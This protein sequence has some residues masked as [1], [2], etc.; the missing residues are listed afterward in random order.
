[1][2]HPDLR[3]IFALL[4]G[5]L[6]GD[7]RRELERHLDG[8]ADCAAYRARVDRVGKLARQAVQA[9]PIPEID[10]DRMESRLMARIAAP[11]A[12]PHPFAWLRLLAPA[13]IAA[14]LVLAIGLQT[15]SSQ[16]RPHD[17][18]IALGPVAAASPLSLEGP[19]A[20][21]TVTLLSGKAKLAA[22][23]GEP[24]RSVTL[25][26]TV[27]EGSL[28]ETAD[29]AR[30]VVQ[31]AL[32]TGF[33]V[34]GGS[35]VEVSAL[36]RGGSV[37]VL[38]SGRVE[39][40]VAKLAPGGAYRVVAGDFLVEVR[41]TRFAVE[42]RQEQTR[43]EVSEGVVS[44]RRREGRSPVAQ[45]VAPAQAT[46]HDGEPPDRA[47]IAHG[48][49]DPA[50]LALY[51]LPS[52]GG[53]S[54]LRIPPLESVRR[55]EV[56]GMDVGSGDALLRHAR[57][58]AEVVVYPLEGDPIRMTVPVDRT[59][60]TFKMPEAAPAAPPT[61]PSGRIDRAAI[62]A[63]MAGYRQQVQRCYDRRLKRVPTLRDRIE[64]SI[65]IGSDGAVTNAQLRGSGHDA[66]VAE[67]I[68]RVANRWTFQA[69]Q[70][71]AV[72]VNVPFSFAPRG[73]EAQGD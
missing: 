23:R 20:R 18:T 15:R 53:T 3:K 31:T 46:F 72:T 50:A 59:S 37:L 71:G 9:A 45:L 34:K 21:G 38:E 11:D 40:R 57:G 68:L 73:H 25:G 51:V 60:V 19:A 27:V 62:S 16:P 55:V 70:G 14:A 6:E 41:G 32:G 12:T 47:T 28:I 64:L 22:H 58:D 44:V 36:R 52:W 8:C 30:V 4:D 17:R 2:S 5:R 69:P 61:R 42:R 13:A 33:Q 48:P 49:A 1:M 24:K 35:F 66:E 26:S 43:V 56:D 39:S 29:S 7:A 10:F 67:C 63:A 54:V 65:T